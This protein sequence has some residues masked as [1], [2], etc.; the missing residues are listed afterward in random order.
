[1][2]GAALHD[3]KPI[4][5]A[6]H[7]IPWQT[8]LP[9][10]A[11]L[12]LVTGTCMNAGKTTAACEI[13]RILK[14]RGYQI[15]GAKLTGV[16]TRR[17]VLN[18][19]DHG[20]THGLSFSDAGLPS[21]TSADNCVVPAAK[22]ILAALAAEQPDA[23]VVEFGDGIMGHYG[24]DLLLQDRELMSHVAAHVLCAN[25]LVAAWGGLRCLEAWGLEVDCISG[26]ATDNSAG[27]SY[28]ESHF[29]TP[30]AN[31]RNAAE[32]LAAL[33]EAKVFGAPVVREVA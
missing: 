8:S 11:P 25:D 29:G 17:D 16:A 30:A 10:C 32:R 22:G 2:L 31:G 20:A 6:E 26:P 15:A 5:L 24:V 7:S 23:I 1:V 3:G 28:I 33:V 19:E 21:T 14:S 12:I 13:I 27:S 18:M 9:R 4:N